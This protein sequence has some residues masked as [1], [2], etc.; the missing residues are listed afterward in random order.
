MQ[1]CTSQIYLFILLQVFRWQILLGSSQCRKLSDLIQNT[2]FWNW[3]ILTLQ[4][5]DIFLNTVYNISSKS[6]YVPYQNRSSTAKITSLL[7]FLKAEEAIHFEGS[8]SRLQKNIWTKL[9]QNYNFSNH[10][11]TS[12]SFNVLF[13]GGSV[14]GGTGCFPSSPKALNITEEDYWK[15]TSWCSWPRRFTTYLKKALSLLYPAQPL[16][17]SARVCCSAGYGTNDGLT[18][19]INGYYNSTN[20]GSPV[21]YNSATAPYDA[22]PWLPDLVLWDYAINDNN[23][24]FFKSREDRKS[25]YERYISHALRL[26]SRP[27]V[28]A[29]D[30]LHTGDDTNTGIQDR[31]AVNRKYSVPMINYL[32]LF[33]NGGGRNTS[34]T[35]TPSS[36]WYAA[37]FRN[38]HPSW[39][40]HVIWAQLVTTLIAR[41]IPFCADEASGAESYKLNEVIAKHILLHGDYALTHEAAGTKRGWNYHYHNHESVGVDADCDRGYSTEFMFLGGISNPEGSIH[42]LKGQPGDT[43]KPFLVEGNWSMFSDVPGNSMKTGWIFEVSNDSFSH[44]IITSFASGAE[45]IA[46]MNCTLPQNTVAFRCHSAA[47]G[48]VHVGYL[49]SYGAQWGSAKVIATAHYTVPNVHK[50]NGNNGTETALEPHSS[51][52][53]Y[54]HSRWDVQNSI[55]QQYVI[56]AG[57][58]T[59][60]LKGVVISYVDVFISACVGMKFKLLSI[61]CC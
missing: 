3:E 49:A 34:A 27:Q 37:E 24:K 20:C 5:N 57:R 50:N 13:H 12:S 59:V 33:R 43:A 26:P 15:L 19:V 42:V 4:H 44:P 60:E 17:I 55:A 41:H 30:F 29:L 22:R 16:Q 58:K 11:M 46:P 53:H 23:P 61:S 14:C 6:V 36:P 56:P 9:K 10:M 28:V 39:P 18:N 31:L 7:S 54:L 45:H 35:L 40:T 1:Y 21:D 8:W 47:Q 32:H 51:I 38:N 48:N 52:A 2:S 25:V